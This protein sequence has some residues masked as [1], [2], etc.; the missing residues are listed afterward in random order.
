MG[1]CKHGR[2]RSVIDV[3]LSLR[4]SDL[5]LK[6]CKLR[7]NSLPALGRL[8]SAGHITVLT[9]ISEGV[10]LLRVGC[11]ATQTFFE[12]LRTSSLKHLDMED[13][14]DDAASAE[15][16]IKGQADARRAARQ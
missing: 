10:P 5:Y 16:I 6:S 3:A 14:G 7:A 13:G 2:V 4:L 8:V 15:A 9:V 1:Q 11:D 12:A